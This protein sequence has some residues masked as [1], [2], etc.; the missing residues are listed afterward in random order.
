VPPEINHSGDEMALMMYYILLKYEK[1]PELRQI[2][3]KGLDRSW[4]IEQ[5]EISPFFNF[6]YG[7][8]TTGNFDLGEL[9]EWLRD[10]PLD[11]IRWGVNNSG[12]R[13]VKMPSFRTRFRREQGAM[14]LP[15]SERPI[16]RWNGNPFEVSSGETGHSKLDGTL[17]LLPY[18]MGRYH[19]FVVE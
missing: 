16:M 4:E 8:A 11:T 6:V 13:D 3:L 15:I 17:W 18:W 19:G 14:L 9:V 10:V 2:Y 7:S 1:D 12:R 5:P